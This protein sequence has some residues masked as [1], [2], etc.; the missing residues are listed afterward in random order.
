MTKQSYEVVGM[1]RFAL[2]GTYTLEELEELVKQLRECN[3]R[4]NEA[5]IKSLEEMPDSWRQDFDDGRKAR[6]K[7]IRARSKT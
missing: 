2:N 6:A 1:A 3:E 4:Y 7:E 5:L